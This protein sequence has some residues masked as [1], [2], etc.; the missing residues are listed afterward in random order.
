[1]DTE[2]AGEPRALQR[3]KSREQVRRKSK[4]ADHA[5]RDGFDDI[6]KI[7]WKNVK[8]VPGRAAR[9]NRKQKLENVGSDASSSGITED[10]ME[11]TAGNSRALQRCQ[12]REISRRKRSNADY[13]D[14]DGFEEIEKKTRKNVTEV[15]GRAVPKNS[16]KRKLDNVESEGMPSGTTD[17]GIELTVDDLVS[18][19]EEIVSADKEKLQG[20]R[21]TKTARY[22]EHP[23]CPPTST[24]DDTGGQVSSAWSTKGL[25]QCTTS[26]TNKTPSERRVDKS[27][28][29][30][31]PQQR[32]SSS[33]QMTG[34]G[35]QDMLNIL[36]GPLWS[37]TAAYE[38][39]SEP[40]AYEKKS[41]PAV[42][43]KKSEP[44]AYEKKSEP[45]A[46]ENKSEIMEAATVN[47]NH[48]PA[49][50]KKDWHAVPQVQ[51]EHVVVKKK[52]SLKDKVAMFL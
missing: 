28:R 33:I 24:S 39:N 23:T 11:L 22:E 34:D 7:N 31:E 2:D 20:R 32:P 26:T 12:G 1:M 35:A 10:E 13:A 41:E 16:R 8:K 17:D 51:G 45:A 48:D 14:K 46:Y 43:E 9:K 4:D 42:Y 25:M 19:A 3:C 52:S 50:R 21:T 6:E 18:I 36:L 38:K 37:K 44:A 5:V 15:T 49:L 27:H 40:A 29:P 30:E 47:V